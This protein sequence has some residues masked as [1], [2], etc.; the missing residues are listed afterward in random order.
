MPYPMTKSPPEDSIGEDKISAISQDSYIDIS[1]NLSAVYED[2]LRIGDIERADMIMSIL[3]SIQ[4][5]QAIVRA[6]AL[7]TSPEGPT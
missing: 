3:S 4:S 5:E 2:L 7:P 1:N 6:S